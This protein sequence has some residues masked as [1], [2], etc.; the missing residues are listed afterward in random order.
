MRGLF[1]RSSLARLG[2]DESFDE[3]ERRLGD[4]APAVVDGEGVT[5]FG[6]LDLTPASYQA[7]VKAVQGG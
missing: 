1:I 6:I 2:R 5:S 3:V 4:L 7:W